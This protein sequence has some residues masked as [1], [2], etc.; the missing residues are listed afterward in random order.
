MIGRNGLL[1]RGGIRADLVAPAGVSF[2]RLLPPQSVTRGRS[3]LR[4]T[5]RDRADRVVARRIPVVLVR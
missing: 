3:V 2:V 1:T 5:W 4:V